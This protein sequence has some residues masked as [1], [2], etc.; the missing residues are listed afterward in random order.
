MI[1]FKPLQGGKTPNGRKWQESFPA[2]FGRTD[3]FRSFWKG[4]RMEVSLSGKKT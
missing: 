1:K 3:P 2:I 4:E